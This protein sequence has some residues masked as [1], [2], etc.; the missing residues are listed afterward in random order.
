[1]AGFGCTVVI[2]SHNMGKYLEQAAVC[3]LSQSHA[4]TEVMVVE[5]GSTDGSDVV[6]ERLEDRCRI[7]RRPQPGKSGALN[8][9]LESIRTEWTVIL[10]ADD[11]WDKS[12]LESLAQLAGMRPETS[13]LTSDAWVYYERGSRPMWRWFDSYPFFTGPRQELEILRR[14]FVFGSAAFRTDVVRSLG[15]FDTELKTSQDYDMWIRMLR[16][17][18]SAAA[19]QLPLAYYRQHSRNTTSRSMNVLDSRIRI[20]GK[21]LA[22]ASDDERNIV[23]RRIERTEDQRAVLRAREA[24]LD[25]QQSARAELLAA[26]RRPSLRPRTRAQSGLAAVFPLPARW[27]WR[28][29]NSES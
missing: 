21:V 23:E 25:N 14:N 2:A 19:T 15:G 22:T 4:P 26:A 1:M 13:L 27:W 5:N 24:L 12:R 18:E 3:A 9:A 16:A 6:L 7:I 29:T 11:W 8:E 28:R 17:G 10:D 20:L